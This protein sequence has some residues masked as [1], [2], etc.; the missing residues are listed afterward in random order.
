MKIRLIIGVAGLLL[1]GAPV[2]AQ[3]D[4]TSATVTPTKLPGEEKLSEQERAERDFLMPV[5]RKQAAALKHAAQEEAAATQT[6]TDMLASGPV[7]AEET[8][9]PEVEAPKV[10]AT[11]HR[12]YHRSSSRRRT[13]ATRKKTVHKSTSTKRRTTS[14]RRR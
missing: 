1:S 6:A 12:T 13:T 11:P 10:A 7:A 9:V 3:G 2:L 8:K 5:R 4:K 14:S